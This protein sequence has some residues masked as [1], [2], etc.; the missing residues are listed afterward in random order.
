MTR[1]L[2]VS[3][4]R[5][6]LRA[7]LAAGVIA[8]G[9]V[10]VGATPAVAGR[11]FSPRWTS[12]TVAVRGLRGLANAGP[13]LRNDA[14]VTM[15]STNQNICWSQT[16]NDIAGDASTLD[17]VSTMLQYDCKSKLL[18][19]SVNTRDS[20][21]TPQ[22]HDFLSAFD[23]DSN[24]GTGCGGS[25]LYVDAAWIPSRNQMLAATFTVDS[26]TAEPLLQTSLTAKR[27]N[28]KNLAVSFDPAP[29][30]PH[31]NDF[32]WGVLIAPDTD[33][34]DVAGSG[35]LFLASIPNFPPS[36]S[37]AF[38]THTTSQIGGSFSAIIPGDFGG[39]SKTDLL[40]YRAGA[41]ADALWTNNGSGGFTSS[42][43]TINGVY[44]AIIP[45]DF[46]HDGHTDLLF[47]LAGSKQ[48]FIW[49]G[50]GAGGFTSRPFTINGS[51][52]IIPGDFNGD[53]YTDL[54]FYA[55]GT[56][57]DYIWTFHNGGYASAPFTINGTYQITPADVTGDGRTDLLFYAPGAPHDYIWP[58]HAA[59]PGHVAFG[60]DAYPINNVYTHIYA[61]DFNG[62]GH[63]DLFLW[64]R[65]WGPDALLR[66]QTAAPFLAA[67]SQTVI[68]E[69]YDTI[70]PGDFGGD[71]KSD[72]LLVA[73]GSGTEQ[74]WEGK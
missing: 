44:N 6:T 7:S 48:D 68:N 62:D 50:N 41:G 45:G 61:G 20:F 57:Q 22:V 15:S 49:S 53:G 38:T 55:R 71:A 9:L 43:V 1:G 32:A 21:A 25:D 74:L 54:L 51:Y 16:R 67:G 70:I 4:A 8:S 40:L 3:I 18:T 60:S 42:P 10:G 34:F 46:N 37:T 2:T 31:L 14:A 29:Y 30:F 47:Y 66:G 59:S 26:C 64:S 63:D 35:A 17:M 28:T 73:F 24:A 13:A 58:A 36:G 33:N 12:S 39:D 27:S 52:R 23:T 65:G 69:F 5:A 19:V 11:G 72:L 56:A